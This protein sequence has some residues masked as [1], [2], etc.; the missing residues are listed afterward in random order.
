MRFCYPYF[1]LQE[2]AGGAAAI[3]VDLGLTFMKADGL[4]NS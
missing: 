4:I 3:S 1:I 2:N